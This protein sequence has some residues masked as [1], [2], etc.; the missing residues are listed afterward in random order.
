MDNQDIDIKNLQF[1][2]EDIGSFFSKSYTEYIWKFDLDGVKRTIT[3]KHSKL[4][5]TRI[6]HLG[7][8]QICK[9][10]KYTYN[11]KYS[12]SIDI[13]NISITQSD[14]T[15]ILK[16]DE[17]PFNKLLNEQKL[18]RFNIIK[19]TFLEN[20]KGKKNKKRKVGEIR[21]FLTFNR[22]TTSIPISRRTE[23]QRNIYRTNISS[24]SYNDI[25]ENINNDNNID[26]S[27]NKNSSM[28]EESS[29]NR[30]EIIMN[31]E[32]FDE[33]YYN[34]ELSEDLS[35][36]AIDGGDSDKDEDENDDDKTVQ[37]SFRPP[38]Y[39][40]FNTENQMDDD[41]DDFEENEKDENN[42]NN[43]NN[44]N[45]INNEN[46]I[47]N[48]NNIDKKK[49]YKNEKEEEKKDNDNNINNDLLPNKSNKNKNKNKKGLKKIKIKKEENK[50]NI[51]N[52]KDIED[53]ENNINNINNDNNINNIN[54]INNN[55]H[56][57]LLGEE[58]Y[59]SSRDKD[60]YNNNNIDNNLNINN[61][62]SQKQKYSDYKS[63]NPSNPF[64]DD[65]INTN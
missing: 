43:I 1:T 31:P 49:E 12:F 41:S 51:I 38:D 65:S 30:K 24:S 44:D 58:I 29:S 26:T 18:R 5:G 34:E 60:L 16:I 23:D 20:D 3:L 15:Y 35:N 52:N 13:H 42:I 21:K 22:G 4:L 28:N 25:S 57:D 53:N 61:I 6:I 63:N 39:D 46:N 48:I 54:N 27:T 9:Y 40:I 33:Y 10:R 59:N 19:E 56:I 47:D 36:M 45:N 14:G 62:L 37:E 64:E 17:I 2:S 7:K 32:R 8:Q 55:D 11:F 50:Y